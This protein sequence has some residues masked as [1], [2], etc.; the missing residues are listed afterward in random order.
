VEP[1]FADIKAIGYR[2]QVDP[3]LQA[4]AATWYAFDWGL[5]FIGL[6]A[7]IALLAALAR[8]ATAY[9]PPDSKV[10]TRITGRA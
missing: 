8:P 3:L 6:A 7:G 2:D 10:G 4:R 5:W 1:T 9:L